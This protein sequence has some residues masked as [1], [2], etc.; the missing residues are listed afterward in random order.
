MRMKILHCDLKNGEIKIRP[1]SL[2]DLWYLKS[3]IKKGDLV[4]GRSY[5]RVRDEE[6][7]RADKGVRVPVNLDIRVENV[8]FA[9]Y[10]NR[11]RVTGRIERGPEDL[12]TL[13]SYHT[14]DIVP[15][16][17]LKIT[18]ER[19]KKW[20]LERLKEAERAATTPLILI[21]CIEEGE[22]ELAVLRRYGLDMLV[23]V[24]ASVAGKKDVKAHE[25]TAKQFYSEVTNKI[26]EILKKE[27]LKAIII[28][29]PGFAKENLLEF[30]REK[31]PDV[32]SK[33]YLESA[34]TG[35]RVGI[36]EILK[37]GIVERIVEEHRVS[38][39]V[40]LIENL[41]VEISKDSGLAAYGVSEVK[42]ALELGAVDKLIV[43]DLFLREFEDADTLIEN[44]K[45]ARG[46]VVVV[47]TE[48]EAGKRL[49][50]IGGIAALLRF[51]VG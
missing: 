38:M 41:F 50:G 31:H 34:G 49:E 18:K 22:A 20:E 32:A 5:R 36:Q 51:K 43:S 6:K 7:L 30:I 29:G 4:S 44:A 19:W 48:H 39:E 23:R 14:L 33:C 3:I 12:I 1:E 11:L 15:N 8:E 25:T 10:T 2:D 17:S 40:K 28:C 46:E 47:S 9:K 24:T 13:G 16:E 26:V 27:K 42:K 35:G 45:K 37:R 21:A